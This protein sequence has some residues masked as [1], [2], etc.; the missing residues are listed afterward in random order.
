M[1]IVLMLFSNT[2][3]FDS[4]NFHQLELKISF[5]VGLLLVICLTTCFTRKLSTEPTD[6][7]DGKDVEVLIDHAK[8]AADE[9]T[10]K[11]HLVK[12]DLTL[13]LFVEPWGIRPHLL[14]R[15]GGE[16]YSVGKK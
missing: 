13:A 12:R 10:D 5:K 7:A 2:A 3:L 9:L 16:L 8:K 11:K 14:A 4:I 6:D 1:Q 15:L